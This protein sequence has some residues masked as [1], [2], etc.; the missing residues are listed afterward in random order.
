[1]FYH[2]APVCVDHRPDAMIPVGAPLGAIPSGTEHIGPV[3]PYGLPLGGFWSYSGLFTPNPQPTPAT[4][5]GPQPPGE[6]PQH[7]QHLETIVYHSGPIAAP[8]VSS[9]PVEVVVVP[10]SSA[11]AQSA[12]QVNHPGMHDEGYPRRSF[13]FPH[14]DQ[15]DIAADSAG[16]FNI[17]LS[18]ACSQCGSFFNRDHY[19]HD[20]FVNMCQICRDR[21]LQ[22]EKAKRLSQIV[23]E[24]ITKVRKEYDEHIQR[25]S[26]E[27][28]QKQLEAKAAAEAQAKQQKEHAEAAVM[29]A[30]NKRLQEEL[31]EYERI[32]QEYKTAEQTA[33]Q[34]FFTERARSEATA[35]RQR[36]LERENQRLQREKEAKR[37]QDEANRQAQEHA[38]QVARDNEV[39][40]REAERAR[41]AFLRSQEEEL[42]RIAAE[43]RAQEEEAA[44]KT[45][46]EEELNR[47]LIREELRAHLAQQP[48][49][50]QST[51][52]PDNAELLRRLAA[53]KVDGN[54]PPPPPPVHYP[55]LPAVHPSRV[56][57]VSVGTCYCF[58]CTQNKR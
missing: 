8:P 44:R 50:P 22:D 20:Q 26:E 43:K 37:A 6:P 30:Q 18:T 40:N 32:R 47:R 52:F 28:R 11:I 51:N 2:A 33:Y 15:I 58:M 13:S 56:V 34:R 54:A 7:G 23:D 55:S 31:R 42:L 17:R 46:E 5:F 3:P 9:V 48:M 39:R 1:V 38:A 14:G 53:L 19:A 4:G 57:H 27:R 45:H 36:S 49:D 12:S 21:S 35:R 24:E 10:P 25:A 16:N 41:Q 29:E